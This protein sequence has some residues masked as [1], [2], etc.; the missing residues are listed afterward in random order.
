MNPYVLLF[1]G[2]TVFVAA[3]VRG[4]CGFGFSMIFTVSL[5]LVLPPAEVVPVVLLL[6]VIASGWLLPQ[7]WKQVDWVSLAPLSAGVVIGTPV[8]ILA[9]ASIPAAPI[10]VSIALVII[11]FVV[12]MWKG[13]HPSRIPQTGS[14][15][16]IGA[17]SG[18]LNGSTTMGGPPVILFYLSGPAAAAVSRASMIAFFLGTDLIAFTM[19]FFGGL[20]TPRTGVLGA[21]AIPP[22]LAGIFC[23]SRL[24]RRSSRERFERSALSLL[25]VLAV[26]AIIRV[27]WQM[28]MPR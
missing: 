14:I 22:L 12:L 21:C 9:L 1:A 4:Y 6:E 24:F 13:W 20:V 2:T 3:V 19:A 11:G 7:V 17:L 5:T 10:R 15:I 27:I 28:I 25:V 8:G 26:A 16:S 18:I 23:G